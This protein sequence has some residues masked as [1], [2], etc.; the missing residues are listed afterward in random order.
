MHASHQGYFDVGIEH[1]RT[2]RTHGQCSLLLIDEVS[3]ADKYLLELRF[4]LGPEWLAYPEM[5]TGETVN[6]IV[7]GPRQLVLQCEA[8][9][10]LALSVMPAQIS[11]EYG[12][13]LAAI[14][15]ASKPQPACLLKCRRGWNGIDGGEQTGERARG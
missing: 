10:P 3:G 14:V 12:A 9:H 5:M 8:A 7:K 6:C 4:M 1:Q 11:R 15:S 13:V 2:V